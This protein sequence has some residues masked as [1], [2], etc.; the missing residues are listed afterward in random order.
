MRA[1]S[2]P[3]YS[4][5]LSA[6]TSEP[7]TGSRARMPTIP[8]H[9]SSGLLSLVAP[10]YNSDDDVWAVNAAQRKSTFCKL[11]ISEVTQFAPIFAGKFQF[12]AMCDSGR[13]TRHPAIPPKKP[14]GSKANRD[15]RKSRARDRTRCRVKK[16]RRRQIH[17][18]RVRSEQDAW[19]TRL[20]GAGPV[21]S[22]RTCA[23]GTR[24]AALLRPRSAKG[25]LHECHR[26][27]VRLYSHPQILR[28]LA[29]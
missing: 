9:T 27:L 14:T 22:I 21:R 20:L 18:L 7:V 10:V 3:R 24:E 29:F 25:T 12:S 6:S 16:I 13:W 1:E 8:A 19:D 26:A 23:P 5:R 17:V 11:L 2:Y 28:V 15:G 4:S